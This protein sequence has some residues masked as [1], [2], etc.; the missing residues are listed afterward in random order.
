MQI[1][2]RCL[3]AAALTAALALLT[4]ACSTGSGSSGSGSDSLTFTSYGSGYQ[5]AQATAWL[6][7]W[8]EEAGVKAIEDQ[9]T[10]YAKIKTMVDAGRVTWDVV[11]TEPFFPVGACGKYAEKLDFTK[12]DKTKFP[13]GTVS[14]CAV[15]D[16]M[17]SLVLVYDPEKY[18]DA[19][20]TSVADFFDTEKFPGK[21]L[22]PGFATGGSMEA[23]LL[24]DGVTPEQLYPLDYDRAFTKLD[25]LGDDLAFWETSAQSQQALESKQA[26]MALVWSGR[27]Y[28][29]AK[30]GSA[31]T[32]VWEDNMLAYAVLMVPKGAP[33]KDLAMD[34]IAYATSA[35]AQSA[36]AEDQPYAAVNSDAKPELDALAEQWNTARAEVQEKG[37]YQDVA[38]WAEN[39]DAATEKWTSWATG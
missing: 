24:A 19:P 3:G 6:E 33:N 13:E 39:Q 30:N 5:K 23:A 25:A 14:D 22:A 37:F 18:P 29:A 32:P 11:D 36:F 27:A 12:I 38:W 16:A 21:R 7:P 2:S 20:P 15:P 35:E 4:T 34:F 28:M 31:Y 26:D 9:P 10:D 8:A 1:R 17:Y